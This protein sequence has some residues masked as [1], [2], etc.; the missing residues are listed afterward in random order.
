MSDLI[1]NKFHFF[2]MTHSQKAYTDSSIIMKYRKC[3]LISY[4]VLKHRLDQLHQLQ[5][6]DP[7]SY[8]YLSAAQEKY[9]NLIT[10]K[11][12][13]NVHQQ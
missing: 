1:T 13:P 8:Q 5:Q 7:A 3:V 6:S 12:L 11:Q 10:N 9:V 2:E 4:L